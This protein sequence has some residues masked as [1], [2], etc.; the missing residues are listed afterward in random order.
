M[1]SRSRLKAA[2]HFKN[3]VLPSAEFVIDVADG[4]KVVV[5]GSLSLVAK[6]TGIGFES[7]FVHVITLRNRKWL[8]FRDFMNTA[9]AAAAFDRT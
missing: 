3:N 5:T 2:R 7:E 6:P 4:G 9:A 1:A 8:R